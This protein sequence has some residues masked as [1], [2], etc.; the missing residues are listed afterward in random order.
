VSIP[1]HGDSFPAMILVGTPHPS[2]LANERL[3]SAAG[4]VYSNQRTQLATEHAEMLL[5]IHENFKYN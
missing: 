4:A 1:T 2:S 3:C 5:F